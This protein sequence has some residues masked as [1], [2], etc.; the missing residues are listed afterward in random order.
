MRTSPDSRTSSGTRWRAQWRTP[1]RTPWP[2]RL[3]VAVALLAAAALR[4]PTHAFPPGLYRDEA[5][6]GLDGLAT[7]VDGPRLWYAANN[8]RE[9]LFIWLVGLSEWA[10]GPVAPTARLPLIAAVRL[11]ALAA[12][13]V[14][15]AAMY[16]L[17][18][19]LAG[20][21]AG[22]I[23]AALT[24]VLP[25]ATL[26][27]RTGL[28]AGLL[29]GVLALSGAATLRGIDRRD[30]RWVAFGGALA[31]LSLHTYTAARALPVAVALAVALAITAPARATAARWLGAAA[32]VALPLAV[33]MARTPGALVGRLAQVA[34]TGDGGSGAS[35]SAVATDALIA[36]FGRTAG[37]VF[38]AGDR[39][40]RHNIPFRPVFGPL[41]AAL[42]LLGIVV[43]C[44]WLRPTSTPRRRRAAAL[45]LAATAAFALPTALAADAP[46]FL[47]AVGLMPALVATASVGGAALV[48]WACARWGT[49]GRTAAWALVALA[50]ALEGR[51]VVHY[52]AALDAGRAAD[53]LAERTV[54]VVAV[55]EAEAHAVPAEVEAV[56]LPA[57]A[58][59]VA[60]PT[61]AAAERLPE[62]VRAARAR[63]VWPRAYHAFDG[64]ATT[65]AREVNAAL[66][67]GRHVWLDRRLRDGWA[68]VP[69]LIPMD[70]V[71][72]T[73]PYDPVLFGDG[74][75]DGGGRDGGG[76]AFIVPYGL[77]LDEVWA[78][79]P[80]DG[81]ELAFLQPIMERG[82]LAA[83]AS[84]LSVR[85]LGP[86]L[87]PE[88]RPS[89][90]ATA[91]FV[92]GPSLDG[93]DIGAGPPASGSAAARDVW[94]PWAAAPGAV[95]VTTRWHID[96]PPAVGDATL[97][98]HV[99]D[100]AGN[101][102]DT[103][104]DAPLGHGVYP[105]GRWRTGDV[106]VDQRVLRLP[107]G[108]HGL[109]IV[110]GLYAGDPDAPLRRGDGA[111]DDVTVE[112]GRVP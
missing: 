22:V 109:P 93:V 8:G 64:G 2:A 49:A 89:A 17:G 3:A 110:A 112:I 78:K 63:L 19:R 33:A 105:V 75:G 54:A 53:P 101:R 100:A 58:E 31:G 65:L 51:D 107:P 96:G 82:D 52:D 20:R 36:S 59:V 106:V 72:L 23:A 5:H 69:F 83:Q 28:R 74:G 57:G 14:L 61:E 11:P 45:L 39:I 38:V 35:S 77:R 44:A 25:W 66:A 97:F 13:V 30:G 55:T 71:T 56:A 29:P 67:S 32:L 91:R 98:I 40:A 76:V 37:L 73:D 81:A 70:R 92:N 87:P 103:S 95:R 27:G 9:P 47:R 79:L 111:G 62:R 90:G 6:Y 42:W 84:P 102:V 21:R 99:R 1:W 10:M 46:H 24:A 7:L 26:L 41:A 15:V 4:A 18:A 48:G 50:V 43:A 12:S 34:V 88:L 85:A 86:R 60:L 108:A 104:V 94:P 80:A 68:S 16:A